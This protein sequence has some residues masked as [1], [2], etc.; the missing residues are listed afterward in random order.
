[1]P[2]VAFPNKTLKAVKFGP[3]CVSIAPMVG[4]PRFS[5]DCLHLNV[6]APSFKAHEVDGFSVG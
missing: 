4:E 1:M 6:F 3:G 5:E 2:P